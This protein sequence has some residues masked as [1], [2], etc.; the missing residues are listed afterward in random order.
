MLADLMVE[1]LVATMAEK[2]EYKLA[3]WM[4]EMLAV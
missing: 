4:V 2:M 3:V 1:Q